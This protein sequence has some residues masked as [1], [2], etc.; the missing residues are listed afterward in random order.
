MVFVG[1]D[2][3]SARFYSAIRG[4]TQGLHKRS[5]QSEAM[6]DIGAKFV[7]LNSYV[8]TI[9]HEQLTFIPHFT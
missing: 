2:L 7:V 4:Q 6:T 3:V 8:L 5:E 9:L 1:A